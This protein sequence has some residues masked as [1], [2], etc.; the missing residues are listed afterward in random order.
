MPAAS[1]MSE[2]MHL[3]PQKTQSEMMPAR[4]TTLTHPQHLQFLVFLKLHVE[5]TW[6]ILKATNV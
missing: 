2:S 1:L 4:F 6:G 3:V 5:L